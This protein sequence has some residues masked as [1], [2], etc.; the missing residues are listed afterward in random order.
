MVLE[1]IIFFKSLHKIVTVAF[2]YHDLNGNAH[3]SKTAVFWQ[4]FY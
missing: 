2:E 4:A 1:R 3:V